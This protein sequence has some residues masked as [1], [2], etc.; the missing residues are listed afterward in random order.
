VVLSLARDEAQRAEQYARRAVSGE[1]KGEA[2]SGEYSTAQ[3]IY[4]V[5]Q[6]KCDPLLAQLE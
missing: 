6:N 5:P 2:R 1:A 3:W 4:G